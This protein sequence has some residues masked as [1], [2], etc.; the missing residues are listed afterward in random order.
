MKPILLLLTLASL[1]H[2]HAALAPVIVNAVRRNYDTTGTNTT[3]SAVTVSGGAGT[4]LYAGTL[5]ATNSVNVGRSGERGVVT[6]SSTNNTYGASTFVD[7]NGAFTV[8]DSPNDDYDLRAVAVGSTNALTKADIIHFMNGT[9]IEARI[10]NDGSGYFQNGYFEDSFGSDFYTRI[11]PGNIRINSGAAVDR[12]ELDAATHVIEMFQGGNPNFLVSPDSGWT[13]SG[14][15]FLS[16]DGHFHPA[17]GGVGTTNIFND[18]VVSNIVVNGTQNVFQFQVTNFFFNGTLITNIVQSGG[19]N[20]WTNSAGTIQA[21]HPITGETDGIAAF[22]IASGIT[23]TSGPLFEWSNNGSEMAELSASGNLVLDGVSLGN[24]PKFQAISS[25]G[26]VQLSSSGYLVLT[27]SSVDL[28]ILRPSIIDGS[29]PYVMDTTLT[30]TSNNVVEFRNNTTNLVQIP[31][32]QDT[33]N[34]PLIL[35]IN[36]TQKRV[37]VGAA[38]SGGTGLRALTIEN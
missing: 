37:H 29:T 17:G 21:V 27:L 22:N 33:T 24:I 25:I 35:N 13:N 9:N 18:I 26:N 7:G 16:D 14:A 10:Y 11:Q 3:T 19:D 6:L 23:H 38:D 5:N 31:V 36:G 32:D 30:H 12:I 34:A 15:I 20:L 28:T 2:T 4:N 8:V 1:L